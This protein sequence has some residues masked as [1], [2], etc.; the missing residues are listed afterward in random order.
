M[1]TYENGI[2]TKKRLITAAYSRLIDNEVSAI[3]V[4]E[5]TKECG[6]SPAALYRHFDGIEHLLIIASIK[7]YEA[8]LIE[9]SRLIKRIEEPI[10]QYLEGWKLFNQYAFARPDIYYR[11]IWGGEQYNLEYSSGFAEYMQLFPLDRRISA[12]A[13]FYTLL[14]NE[15]IDSVDYLVLQRAVNQGKMTDEDAR[16]YSK[17]NPLLAKG[18]LESVLNKCEED[19][20]KAKLECDGLIMKNMERVYRS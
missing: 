15:N 11:L 17:S 8:Y 13:M 14:F 16:Y 12:Q 20:R 10:E 6:C 7:V 9:Y 1:A 2:D 3:T 18:M 5:I 4:R 19:R